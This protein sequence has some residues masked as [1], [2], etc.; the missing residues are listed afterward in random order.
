M[1]GSSSRPRAHERGAGLELAVVAVVNRIDC[2]SPR[3][4]MRH[5]VPAPTALHA[6]APLLQ[7]LALIAVP[8]SALQDGVARTPPLGWSTWLSFRLNVSDSLLRTSTDFLASSPLKAAGYEYI[9]L[10]DGWP[11]CAKLD[12]SGHCLELPPR[13]ADGRIPVDPHKFPNGFKPITDYA[14]SK[15]L[16]IGIYTGVSNRTCGGCVLLS[17][18]VH[19]LPA[20]LRACVPACLSVCLSACLPA[21]LCFFCVSMCRIITHICWPG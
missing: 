16:K 13:D 8:T 14:H 7:L 17:T 12:S 4:V 1:A 6:R 5:T 20:C 3:S 10:D 18:R 19:C 11:S 9:L 21:C 2:A 15:G